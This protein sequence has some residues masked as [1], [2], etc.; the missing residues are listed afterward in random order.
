MSLPVPERVRLDLPWLSIAKILTTLALVWVWLQVWPIVMVVLVSLVL[1]VAL[2]PVVRCLE[3]RRCS[4]GLAVVIVGVVPLALAAALIVAAGAPIAGQAALVLERVASL[5]ETIATHM[6]GA[7]ARAMRGGAGDPSQMMSAI[8]SRAPAIGSAILT[9]ATMTLFAFILTLYLLAD[10]HRTYEWVM[11]YVPRAHR[12]KADETI[13]GVT[14]AVFAYAAGNLLT[15]L[16]A[17]LFV[18]ASVL[19]LRVPAPLMLALLAG[20]CDFVPIV[21]FFVAL[22]PAVLLAFT[23]S[24]RTA[25]AT[26]GLYLLCSAIESYVLAPR[27]YGHHLKLS[28]VAV[29]MALAIGAAVGGIIGAL[30]ALP[31]VA[32]Y[33]IIERIWLRESLGKTVL[34]EHARLEREGEPAAQPAVA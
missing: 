21:G 34:A 11:A 16:F 3:Q 1:A 31:T 33:P 2:E 18:L 28:R 5:P 15:S 17:G 27:V 4:R 19:V 24:P 32:A 13:V 12:A 29:L 26:V 14:D 10:G 8:A 20:V 22:A 9:A 23:V 30:L 25:V 6:P 7:A